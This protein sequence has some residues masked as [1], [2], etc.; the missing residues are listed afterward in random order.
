MLN[1]LNVVMY[2]K[3]IN[4]NQIKYNLDLNRETTHLVFTLDQT[5]IKKLRFV[6]NYN[7]YN[8]FNVKSYDIYTI[9]YRHQTKF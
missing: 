1:Y 6:I 7:G 4:Y 2:E 9:Y 5:I 3:K 8:L